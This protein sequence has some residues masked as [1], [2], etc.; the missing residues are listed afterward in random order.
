MLNKSNQIDTAY[1]LMTCGEFFCDNSYFTERDG[2][3]SMLAI[4]TLEGEGYFKYNDTEAVLEPGSLVVMN[5]EKYNLYK[6]HGDSGWRFLW[7]F[8]N[9]ETGVKIEEFINDKSIFIGSNT[10]FVTDFNYIKVASQKFKPGTDISISMRIHKIM[11]DLATQKIFN[12]SSL[13]KGHVEIVDKILL[14]LDEHYSENITT[15][16][17]E[18]ITN[19]SKYYIIRIFKEITNITPHQY[20]ILMRITKSQSLLRNKQLSIEEIALHVGFADINNY[21]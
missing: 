3:K 2:V 5:S 1:S 7:I 12:K 19:L 4:S 9:S 21:I 8:F 13:K 14:Y 11:S 20:L 10:D 17:F 18:K 15:E 6:T 16:T